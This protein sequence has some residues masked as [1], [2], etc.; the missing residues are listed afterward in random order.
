MPYLRKSWGELMTSQPLTRPIPSRPYITPWQSS[1]SFPLFLCLCF[2]LTSLFLSRFG[3]ESVRTGPST[4]SRAR[5][6][7]TPKIEKSGRTNERNSEERYGLGIKTLSD[8]YLDKQLCRILSSYP[9]L[10]SIIVGIYVMDQHIYGMAP[11]SF[12]EYFPPLGAE[13]RLP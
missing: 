1:I 8:R 13:K 2:S 3:S 10:L 6:R 5:R 4:T 9:F 12:R 11:P 7:C